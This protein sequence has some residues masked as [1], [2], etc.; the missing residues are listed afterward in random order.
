MYHF[1]HEYAWKVSQSVKKYHSKVV[2]RSM[3]IFTSDL[4]NTWALS[5][6]VLFQNEYAWVRLD[7]HPIFAFLR[8]EHETHSTVAAPFLL[9][10]NQS[11]EQNSLHSKTISFDMLPKSTFSSRFYFLKKCKYCLSWDVSQTVKIFDPFMKLWQTNRPSNLPTN[12]RT[13]E[14]FWKI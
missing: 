9:A 10:R 3:V 8:N 2:Q 12:G 11:Q 5:K 7:M 1:I 13:W 14:V 6:N 4:S